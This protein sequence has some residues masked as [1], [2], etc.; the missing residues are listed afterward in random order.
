MQNRS[1]SNEDGGDGG[2]GGGMGAA[3]AAPSAPQS[4]PAM[5]VP[6]GGGVLSASSTS[7]AVRGVD[8]AT[9][10]LL[11]ARGERQESQREQGERGGRRVQGVG[12][13][14]CT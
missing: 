8:S 2:D 4:G 5:M 3:A 6:P 1:N 7:R 11:E 13:I 10:P 14:W 12:R 9:A